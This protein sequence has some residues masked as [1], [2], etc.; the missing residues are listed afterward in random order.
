MVEGKRDDNLMLVAAMTFGE[1][2]ARV[3]ILARFLPRAARRSC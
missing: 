3:A 1:P 2:R